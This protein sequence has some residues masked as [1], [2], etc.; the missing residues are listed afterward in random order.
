MAQVES[1]KLKRPS[2][3]Y[4]QFENTKS[5]MRSQS[6]HYS[7]LKSRCNSVS[8][9]LQQACEQQKEFAEAE[10]KISSWL[11]E[12]EKKVDEIKGQ[13]AAG[14]LGKLQED[15]AK[16]KAFGAETISHG[17]LIEK[18][19]KAAKELKDCLKELNFD[20]TDFGD[21]L[22]N[23]DRLV[24]RFSAVE[25][26]AS[27]KA[28]ELQVVLVQSQGALEG[29]GAMMDWVKDVEGKLGAF[30]P[31]SLNSESLNAQIEELK[32]LKADVD[33]HA[34]SI[35]SVIQSGQEVIQSC[36]DKKRAD[37]IKATLSELTSRFDKINAICGER[38]SQF[39]SIAKQL[40]SFQDA[41]KKH[42]EWM[43]PMFDVLDSKDALPDAL[44]NE[45]ARDVELKESNLTEMQTALKELMESPLVVDKDKVREQLAD[46]EQG[47]GEFKETLADREKEAAIR[48][49]NEARFELLK[50]LVYEWLDTKEAL[51]DGF[52]PIAV[53]RELIQA[54]IDSLQVSHYFVLL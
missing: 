7:S 39:Q 17:Q 50:N 51:A 49:E 24:D 13:S 33:S 12:A 4:E 40:S 20:E 42:K 29:I 53:E 28:N 38:E 54:Q 36:K 46:I 22:S 32:L 18:L 48:N 21:V 52:D 25:T 14:D 35:N 45:V 2:S 19:K 34:P 27:A 41:F 8:D 15:L 44:V 16:V 3:Q 30:K 31:I 10:A 6:E 1:K 26:E 37:E 23:I 47:W 11:D 9:R 5:K 43:T